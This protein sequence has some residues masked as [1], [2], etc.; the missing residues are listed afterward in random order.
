MQAKPQFTR[1]GL[2]LPSTW[3]D[4]GISL[5]SVINI[6]NWYLGLQLSSLF[7]FFIGKGIFS[8]ILEGTR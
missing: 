7:F 5:S 4:V 2:V 1:L 8:G 6:G 3:A